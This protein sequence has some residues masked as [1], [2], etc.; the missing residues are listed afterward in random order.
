MQTLQVSKISVIRHNKAGETI[1]VVA[2]RVPNKPSILRSFHQFLTDLK[3][4][5][6][7]TDEVDSMSDP[8]VL[9]VLADLQGGSVKGDIS[10]HK[11]GDE[12]TI[13]ENSSAVTNKQ[14]S[15]YGKVSVGD[16]LKAEKDGA[17][18]ID[19][20]LL[21]KREAAA[22]AIYKSANS[23]AKMRMKFE[24]FFNSNDDTTGSSDVVS[25]EEAFELDE[26]IA[27][28]VVGEVATEVKK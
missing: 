7:I 16:K 5:F 12:Y 3:E 14:H 9:D 13:D 2:I 24:G 11:E 21:L 4:S 15:L 22:Q 17:R 18:V 6:L 27:K 20:F 10:F 28:E 1:N 26:D 25:A 8:E 23:Y 19:G